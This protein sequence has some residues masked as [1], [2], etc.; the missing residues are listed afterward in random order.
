MR[1]QKVHSTLKVCSS[2]IILACLNAEYILK[3]P[4]HILTRSNH[5]LVLQ[6]SDTNILLSKKAYLSLIGWKKMSRSM[7]KPILWPVHSAKTQISLGSVLKLRFPNEE[8]FGSW[9][10]IKRTGKTLIRLGGCPGWSESSLGAHVILFVLSFCGSDIRVT[11]PNWAASSEFGTYRICEQRRFRRACASVQS[12]Q[13]LRC[14][15]IQAV[16]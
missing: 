1:K 9:L 7:T 4:T 2:K 13:N 16:S 8:A 11:F 5:C 3:T 15:L 14:S 6:V 10:P 12:R